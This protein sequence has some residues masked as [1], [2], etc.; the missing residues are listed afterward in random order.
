MDVAIIGCVVNGPGE[1]KQVDIGLTGG[2]PNNLIYIDG[3]PSQKLSQDNLVD[4]LEALIRAKANQKAQQLE[5]LI[6]KSS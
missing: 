5:A 2:T 4:E 3:K 6:A 1:A